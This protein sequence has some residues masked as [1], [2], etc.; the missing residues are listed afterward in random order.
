MIE[1]GAARAEITPPVGTSLAGY[2]HARKATSV[3]D[4]LFARALVVEGKDGKPAAVVSLDVIGLGSEDVARLR[5]RAQ[6]AAGLTGSR[7]MVCCTHT[8]TGP[9]TVS[10]LA[11]EKDEQATELVVDGAVKALA[12]AARNMR[13]ARVGITSA[14]HAGVGF[15]RRF[16]M[17]DGTVR[18]NPGVGNPDILEPAGPVDDELICVFLATESGGVRAALVNFACHADIVSGDRISADYPGR[19]CE[20]LGQATDAEEVLFVNGAFGDIN[21]I[22]VSSKSQPSGAELATRIGLGI[23]L[24]ASSLCRRAAHSEA[25][26]SVA[27]A[28]RTVSVGLRKPDERKLSQARSVLR[29]PEGVAAAELVYAREAVKLAEMAGQIEL[30]IMGIRIGEF[31]M[32]ALP[33]EPFTQVGL[34]IKRA[35]PFRL[36]AVAGDANGYEGYLPTRKAFDEGGYE[37]RLARSSKLE[38]GAAEKVVAEAAEVLAELRSVE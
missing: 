11:V 17:R 28:S 29:R 3:L 8:H 24:H 25:A 20:T 19:L 27:T 33:C 22:D 18:T 12:S 37:V 5:E 16:R 13:P 15:N 31:A 30:E 35:S 34:E 1:V 23:A 4:P 21:H 32:V 26:A 2:F 38:P 36:T 9:A 7:I 10:V 6:A 14:P